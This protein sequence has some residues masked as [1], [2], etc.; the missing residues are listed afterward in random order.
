M[1]TLNNTI[2]LTNTILRK[3]CYAIKYLRISNIRPFER[4]FTYRLI[5]VR[6][7]GN[8]RTRAKR[9]S[10]RRLYGVPQTRRTEKVLRKYGKSVTEERKKCYA[11]TE[12]VLRKVFDKSLLISKLANIPFYIINIIR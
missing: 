11:S 10:L 7:E 5:I 12:K 3:K 1:I 2:F 8:N 9:N 6:S 4:R